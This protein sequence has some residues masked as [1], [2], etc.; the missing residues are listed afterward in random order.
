MK[1]AEMIKLLKAMED[2]CHECA[3]GFE[4]NGNHDRANKLK[5]EAMGYASVIQMLASPRFAK[6]MAAIYFD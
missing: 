4:E 3:K 2:N 6:D 1:K 5:G